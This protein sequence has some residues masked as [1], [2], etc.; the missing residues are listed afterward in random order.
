MQNKTVQINNIS[1]GHCVKTIERE[2]S[3]L[4]GVKEVIANQEKKEAEISWDEP[5]TWEIISD[6]LKEIGYPVN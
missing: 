2:I 6:T 5:A 1:C 3:E 4:E